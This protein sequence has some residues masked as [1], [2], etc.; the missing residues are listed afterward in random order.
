MVENFK[1]LSLIYTLISID[2]YDTRLFLQVCSCLGACMYTC[3]IP[4]AYLHVQT[5]VSCLSH[6][7]L[8]TPLHLP[9][10][11]FPSSLLSQTSVLRCHVSDT[12]VPVAALQNQVTL[13]NGR[14]YSWSRKE[15][16]CPLSA[17]NMHLGGRK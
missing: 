1:N 9:L 16:R 11:S 12:C 14:R 13:Q 4:R 15:A 8:V 6:T 3:L 10:I 2:S 5:D 17:L 7:A